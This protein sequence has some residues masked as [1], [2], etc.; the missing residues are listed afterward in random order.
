MRY[1]PSYT[2]AN[3]DQYYIALL[4]EATTSSALVSLAE[5]SAK[6]QMGPLSAFGSIKIEYPPDVSQM[7]L[8]D[9]GKMEWHEI[10][11]LLRKVLP[12]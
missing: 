8:A 5:Q 10:E 2:R 11:A 6:G 7:S 3:S 4:R 1:T 9:V 12:Q